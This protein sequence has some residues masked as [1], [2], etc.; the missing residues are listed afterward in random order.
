MAN[1]ASAGWSGQIAIAPPSGTV[2]VG[3]KVCPSPFLWGKKGEGSCWL[4]SIIWK[5]ST[6]PGRDPP[7]RDAYRMSSLM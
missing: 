7:V 3:W 6:K 5:K 1:P 2:G 4:Q